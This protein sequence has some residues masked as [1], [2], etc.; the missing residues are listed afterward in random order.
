MRLGACISYGDKGTKVS[1]VGC[2]GM[3]LWVSLLSVFW[4]RLH[5]SYRQIQILV[6]GGEDS[7]LNAW[8]INTITLDDDEVDRDTEVTERDHSETMTTVSEVEMASPKSRKRDRKGG[9]E[10]V[11]LFPHTT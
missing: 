7:K 11:G 9:F 1:C 4:I 5:V 8:R 2:S 6:T 3:N 10:K